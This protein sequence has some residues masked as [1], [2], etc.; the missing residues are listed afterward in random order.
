MNKVQLIGRLTRDPDIRYSSA[1]VSTCIAR[2]TLAVD[3]SR[4][5]ADGQREADFVSC[6]AFG[7]LGELAEKYFHKGIKIAVG[8][9]IQTGSYTNK[10]GQRVYTTDVIVEDCEF[11]ESKNAG[12]QGQ[13]AGGKGQAAGARQGGY[14]DSPEGFMDIPD[15]LSGDALPFN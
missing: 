6:V 10:D 4:K 11:V 2:F 15:D 3:R 12:A 1:E 7:K 13:T 9:R 8:G 14:G 5:S